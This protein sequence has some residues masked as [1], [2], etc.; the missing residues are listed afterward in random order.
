MGVQLEPTVS[1]ACVYGVKV[2]EADGRAG[3]ICVVPRRDEGRGAV[4]LGSL[5]DRMSRD[6]PP[7]AVPLF[8]RVA[9]QLQTTSTFKHKKHALVEQG[10]DPAKV[11]DPLFVRLPHSAEWTELTPALYAAIV[12]REITL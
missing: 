11:G 1:E 12:R 6:L 2:P 9:G 4:D 7:Y 10:F 8:V 3:M 5:L